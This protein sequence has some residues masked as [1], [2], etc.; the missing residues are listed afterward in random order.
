MYQKGSITVALLV[1]LVVILGGA[2]GYIFI[3]GQTLFTFG[4]PASLEEPQGGLQDLQKNQQ[5]VAKQAAPKPVATAIPAWNTP[6]DWKTHTDAQIGYSIQY[7]TGWNVASTGW[8]ASDTAFLNITSPDYDEKVQIL[9]H[10]IQLGTLLSDFVPATNELTGTATI[11][12]SITINTYPA[13]KTDGGFSDGTYYLVHGNIGYILQVF[14]SNS[15]D[16]PTAIDDKSTVQKIL[17][18]FTLL[19]ISS[20]TSPYGLTAE[21]T[22]G[23]APLTVQFSYPFSQD[24]VAPIIGF[25]DGSQSPMSCGRGGCTA[26]HTYAKVGTYTAQL[27]SGDDVVGTVTIS[28]VSGSSAN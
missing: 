10:K 16:K 12:D 19:E 7:P 9:S 22:S 6:K 21:P 3:E 8:D 25:G 4:E 26:S 17:H 13:I 5:V 28:V 20:D 11:K 18:S 2:L 27:T 14:M 1:G 23:S 24:K 15:T